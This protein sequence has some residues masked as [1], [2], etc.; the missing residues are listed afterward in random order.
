[1]AAG[2]SMREEDIESLRQ[3]LNKDSGLSPEDFVPRVH[4]D[5]PMPL[6]YA[7]EKLAGELSLLEPFG[8]GNPK[9]LFAQ[10]DLCFLAGFK[11]GATKNFARFKVRTPEGQEMQLVYFGSPEQF[12]RFLQE[13][14]GAGSEERLYDGQG[15][16]TLSVTYQLGLNTYRGRTEL[17][18][19]MQNY[20]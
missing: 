17:Q 16:F 15:D 4:I 13:K 8:V 6:A 9:P 3:A 2:L 1:M 7:D 18:F 19:I 14:Y 12:G 5:V 11:M 20:C 10:K